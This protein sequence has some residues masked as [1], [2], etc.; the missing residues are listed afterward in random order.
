[1]TYP[2]V[3]MEWVDTLRC[4]RGWTDLNEV[5]EAAPDQAMAHRTV[6]YLVREGPS[7]IVVV[8]SYQ[9]WLRP[10]GADGDRNVLGAIR[11]PARAVT[12]LRRL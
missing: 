8:G 12:R 7:S 3:E 5:L 11:I 1:M 2:I 10:E 4:S 9:D 6:G